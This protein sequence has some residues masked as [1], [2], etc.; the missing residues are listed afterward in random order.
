MSDR[1]VV[2]DGGRFAQIGTPREI[3]ERPESRFVAAFI[4]DA[5]LIDGVVE[6]VDADVVAVRAAGIPEPILVAPG[7]RDARFP[8]GAP[9]T[10][11]V[12]PEQVGIDPAAGAR[13]GRL[14]AT[15]E[16]VAYQGSACVTLFRL[17]NGQPFRALWSAASTHPLVPGAGVEIGWAAGDA[18]LVAR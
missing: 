15:M 18:R 6:R 11:V 14:K 13:G 8:V 12:R 4:G 9:V 10:V 1:I 17:A 7:A 16:A 3:Y 2:M 5:N